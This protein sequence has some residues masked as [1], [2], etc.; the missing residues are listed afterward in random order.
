MIYDL[1]GISFSLLCRLVTHDLTSLLIALK[2][3]KF[4]TD[5]SNT[6][7]AKFTS[8]SVVHLLKDNRVEL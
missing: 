2:A 5:S 3:L 8:S 4:S 1:F 6:F 7:A